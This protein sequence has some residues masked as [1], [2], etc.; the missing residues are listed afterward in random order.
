MDIPELDSQDLIAI[1]QDKAKKAFEKL[2]KPLIV[3]DSGIYF[4]EYPGFPGPLAKRVF[5]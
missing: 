1:S 4:D 2:K 5:K 3:D